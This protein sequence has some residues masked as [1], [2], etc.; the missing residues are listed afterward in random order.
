MIAY[1]IEVQDIKPNYIRFC[2]DSRA[3]PGFEIRL[4]G[5]SSLIIPFFPDHYAVILHEC[6]HL[7]SAIDHSG[8]CFISP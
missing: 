6:D 3:I 8:G 7:G 1:G 4:S 5:L 2:I